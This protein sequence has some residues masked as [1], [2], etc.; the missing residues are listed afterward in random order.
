MTFIISPSSIDN[1][2]DVGSVVSVG[3]V[4]SIDLIPTIS[5]TIYYYRFIF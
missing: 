4:D 5:D 3:S 1:D 2:T